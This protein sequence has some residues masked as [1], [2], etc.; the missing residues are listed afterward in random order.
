[1]G[2][3][4]TVLRTL[5]R[6][7]TELI[8]LDIATEQPVRDPTTGLCK[9]TKP[10]TPGELVVKLD[11]NNINATFQGYLGNESASNKKLLRDVMKKGDMFYRSGD[12]VRRNEDGMTYFVDRIGDTFRWKSE[13]VATSEVAEILGSHP[14]IVEANVYGVLLPGHDGRAGCA[15]IVLEGEAG[16][17]PDERLLASLAQ[18]AT[19]NLASYARPVFLRFTPSFE[20]TGTNKTMKHLMREEGADPA[21][22]KASKPGDRLFWLRKGNYVPFRERDWE[23]LKS[24]VVRL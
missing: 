5:F 22:V 1:M 8:Q 12:L 16:R 17:E 4:G 18:H 11:E 21:K 9:R 13:N 2:R 14:A 24:G 7:A 23:S 6:G 10:N 19:S 15:A 3:S 20:Q